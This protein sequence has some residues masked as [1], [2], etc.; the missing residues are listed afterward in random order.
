[1]NCSK[2]IIEEIERKVGAQYYNLEDFW[3]ICPYDLDTLTRSRQTKYIIYLHVGMVWARLSG[4]SPS[5]AG[6]KF[7]RDRTTVLNAE[8]LVL[9]TLINPKFGRSEYITIIERIINNAVLLPVTDD[10]WQNYLISN[11]YME[12]RLKDFIKND[13]DERTIE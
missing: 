12:T 6:E 4:L 11:V 10:V 3:Y 2:E 5:E 1:M 8:N 7:K 13:K 9:R